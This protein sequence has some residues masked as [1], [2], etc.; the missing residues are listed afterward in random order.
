MDHGSPRLVFAAVAT[1]ALLSVLTV[2]SLPR[3]AA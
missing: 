2:I 3:K 1:F